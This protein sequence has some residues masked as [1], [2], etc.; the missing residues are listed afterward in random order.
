ML[1]TT[2]KQTKTVNPLEGGL[3]ESE[4]RQEMS[5]LFAVISFSLGEKP[6]NALKFEDGLCVFRY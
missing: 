6:K 4:K 2:F 5:S 1:P 3:S